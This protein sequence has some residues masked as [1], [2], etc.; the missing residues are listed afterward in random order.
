[1][2]RNPWFVK[3]HIPEKSIAPWAPYT[4]SS[5]LLEPPYMQ[6]A[7]LLKE[8]EEVHGIRP[9]RLYQQGFSHAN[10][11]GACVRGGQAQWAHLLTV[12]PKRYAEWEAEEQTTRVVLEKDVAI[13]T[14]T[15]K[16]VKSPIT[17]KDFREEREAQITFDTADWGACGC[18]DFDEEPEISEIKGV[19]VL[20]SA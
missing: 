17:L 16:G 3:L 20:I 2:F 9:P 15:R 4:I 14:R 13:L 11:G 6:K 18:T 1:M 12:N 8:W 5:P 10:C 19:P 7:D